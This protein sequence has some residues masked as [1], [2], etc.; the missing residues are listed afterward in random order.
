MACFVIKESIFYIITI[1]ICPAKISKI[2]PISLKCPTL[3]SE[4]SGHGTMVTL[5]LLHIR[6]DIQPNRQ[7]LN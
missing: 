4:Q 2:V 1:Y 6:P 3:S 5:G 7:D